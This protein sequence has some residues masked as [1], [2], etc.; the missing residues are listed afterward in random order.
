MLTQCFSWR[1][2]FILLFVFMS[3]TNKNR[4]QINMDQCHLRKGWPGAKES[5]YFC[6]APPRIHHNT[7]W[8]K[9]SVRLRPHRGRNLFVLDLIHCVM[10]KTHFL[11]EWPFKLE[12]QIGKAVSWVISF[13]L[14]CLATWVCCFLLWCSLFGL[15]PAPPWTMRLTKQS[16]EVPARGRSSFWKD[17]HLIVCLFKANEDSC[18]GQRRKG[19]E[20][21]VWGILF[22]QPGVKHEA[23][24]PSRFECRF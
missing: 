10:R 22:G 8:P 16:K 23:Y 19:R 11:P 17:G 2:S 6:G 9:R 7:S 15:W 14:K 5:S 3:K 1:C 21:R 13:L 12:Q 24:C 4:E 18:K 20:G